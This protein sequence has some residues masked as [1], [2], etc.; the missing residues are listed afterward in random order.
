VSDCFSLR[1][2]EAS[3]D[4]S[5]SA[6]SEWKTRYETKPCL[7]LERLSNSTGGRLA[8]RGNS[9]ILLTVGD[10]GIRDSVLENDPDFPYGKVLELDRARWT[11]KV[12]TRGNRN[13]QGLLVDGG[14]IWATE[15]GPHGGDE[16]NLLIEGLDYGWPRET[17][18]TNYGKKTFKNNPLIGD[19]S[20]SQRPVYAWI[21][22]IGISNLVKVRGDAFP[23]WNGD[24]MVS[25][26]TGQRNGRSIF[27]VRV[28]EGRAVVVERLKTGDVIRD[29]VELPGKD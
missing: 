23:A 9:S 22:S 4:P 7:K 2:L 16:L 26:L 12:F 18:G 15:H 20:Q 11:H 8:L 14:E 24:L 17:Y 3:I 13:P 6:A 27:R 1:L 25:S 28:R 29:L 10:F 21:P 19:H 5:Y